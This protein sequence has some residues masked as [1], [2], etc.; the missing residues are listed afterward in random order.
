MSLQLCVPLTTMKANYL[1]TSTRLC[2][3]LAAVRKEA[4]IEAAAA[5]VLHEETQRV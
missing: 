2:R 5:A 3:Q 4:L 1:K